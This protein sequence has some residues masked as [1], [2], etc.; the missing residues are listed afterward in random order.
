MKVLLA[1]YCGSIMAQLAGVGGSDC[2]LGAWLSMAITFG[3]LSRGG[4]WLGAF[5]AA[6]PLLSCLVLT[7]TVP[8]EKWIFLQ[9]F[10]LLLLLFCSKNPK[11][12]FYV[13]LPIALVLGGMFLLMP[14]ETYKGQDAA[15]RAWAWLEEK[16]PKKE[17]SSEE[18][19][20][21]DD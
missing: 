2:F 6:L 8:A 15:E 1:D 12:G 18:D 19:D 14:Q 17:K 5:C 21:D 9:L 11:R 16:F 7:D 3:Y 13:A 20:E 10:S 4:V